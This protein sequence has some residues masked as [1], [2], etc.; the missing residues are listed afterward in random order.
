M[1]GHVGIV[2]IDRIAIEQT[3]TLTHAFTNTIS[4]VL[5]SLQ[6]NS[7]YLHPRPNGTL[8]F[9]ASDDGDV[10]SWNIEVSLH[11]RLFV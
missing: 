3:L 7:I 5:A 9:S 10:F 11:V 4:P 1:K 2:R 6:I 8:L